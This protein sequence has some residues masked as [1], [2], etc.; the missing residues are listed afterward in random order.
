MKTKPK[1]KEAPE[2]FPTE[3]NPHGPVVHIAPPPQPPIPKPLTDAE[4]V[5][6]VLFTGSRSHHE[7]DLITAIC[8]TAVETYPNA[9]FICGGAKGADCM[10]RFVL[11]DK[12]NRQVE[13]FNADWDNLGNGAGFARN[14]QMLMKCQA[15]VALWDG[16]SKGTKHTIDNA[17]RLGRRVHI[18]EIPAP[19]AE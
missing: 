1:K 4:K 15:V 17:R 18:W 7:W 11:V 10:A 16:E 8:Q 6:V 13:T 9:K 12:F 2:F 19:P 14:W 3:D 5:K